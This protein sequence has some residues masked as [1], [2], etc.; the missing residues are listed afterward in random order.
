MAEW[1]YN[2]TTWQK[3]RKRKLAETPLCEPCRVRGDL[4]TANTVDHNTP[5][6]KGGQPFPPLDG[7]TSMCAKCHNEKTATFDRGKPKPFARRVK[8]F[9]ALGN[10]VDQSDEWH[11]GGVSNH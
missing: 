4:V 10:P 5:I 7:L 8:G 9:D 6:A 1:P 11:T 3:L 2:T